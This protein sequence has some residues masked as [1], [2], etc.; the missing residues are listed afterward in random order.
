MIDIYKNS[1]GDE[2]KIILLHGGFWKPMYN[3]DHLRPFAAALAE[4]A[5]FFSALVEYRRIS[6]D[7]DATVSDVK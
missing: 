2:P 1:S 7:P 4:K 3:R 6:G 5:G